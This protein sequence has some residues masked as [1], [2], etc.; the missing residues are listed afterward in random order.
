MAKI[1]RSAKLVCVTVPGPAKS[2]LRPETGDTP[3]EENVHSYWGMWLIN[4]YITY[5]K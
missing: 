2:G 1:R 4:T 3:G 5:A